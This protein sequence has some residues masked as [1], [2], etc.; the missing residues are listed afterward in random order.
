[1]PLVALVFGFVPHRTQYFMSTTGL[2]AA[3]VAANGQSTPAKERI[4]TLLCLRNRKEFAKG[5]TRPSS[6]P[7]SVD[8][9]RVSASHRV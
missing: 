2:M 4:E 7:F 1:M 3:E 6:I 8:A 5:M 9:L